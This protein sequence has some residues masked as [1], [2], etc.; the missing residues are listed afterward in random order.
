MEHLPAMYYNRH[1]NQQLDSLLDFVAF[2]HEVR[3]IQRA[4]WVKDIE[5]FENDSEHCYQVALCAMFIITSQKLNLDVYRTMG[6]ALVHDVLEVYAGDTPIFASQD[7][8]ATKAQR[9]KQARTMLKQRWPDFAL[10]HDLIDE[11]EACKTNESKFIYALDKLL[12]VLNNYLDNGRNWKAH[13]RK[14]DE[15]IAAKAGK[16]T[17]DPTIARYYESIITVLRNKPEL[18][19]K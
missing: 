8:L 17:K 16:V 3:A 7:T 11:Y 15:V 10:M 4:M 6:M 19:N 18:F 9:E 13:H 14:L 2:T 5:Q 1:M 12:P